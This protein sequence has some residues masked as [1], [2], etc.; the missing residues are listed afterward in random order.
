MGARA[1]PLRHVTDPTDRKIDGLWVRSWHEAGEDF[2]V[3]HHTPAGKLWAAMRTRCK[4]SPRYRG[5]KIKFADFQQFAEWCQSCPGYLEVDVAG[6]QYHLDKDLRGLGLRE[7]GPDT[8]CFIPGELNSLF[9]FSSA[10][11]G[12][13]PIGV[14]WAPAEG[15]FKA[16]I[17]S[18][19]KRYLGRFHT[20]E[21]AHREWQRAKAQEFRDRAAELPPLLAWLEQPL[22]AHARAIDAEREAGIETI[23]APS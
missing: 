22:L 7:Y 13:L 15:V 17:S 21:E 18:R 23:R 4:T 14:H 9:T 19:G 1:R 3:Q 16:Q 8:C 6:R 11:R 20:S 2:N 10:T 12:R 5:V